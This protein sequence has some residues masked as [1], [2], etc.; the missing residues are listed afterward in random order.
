MLSRKQAR[1]ERRWSS[2]RQARQPAPKTVN[3]GSHVR[4]LEIEQSAGPQ[5][6]AYFAQE[7]S[8]VGHVLDQVD[9]CDDPQAGQTGGSCLE[10]RLVGFYSVL[11]CDRYGAAGDIDS[12]RYD[13]EASLRRAEQGSRVAS[14]VQPAFA[15]QLRRAE[16]RLKAVE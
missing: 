15:L 5:P 3:E 13:S 12:E 16:R 14:D 9:C 2:T 11:S 1:D 8:R 6:P 10:R 7:G 4:R